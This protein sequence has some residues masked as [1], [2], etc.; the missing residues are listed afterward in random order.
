MSNDAAPFTSP[1]IRDPDGF[2]RGRH[3]I[4]TPL[5]A[6][7]DPQVLLRQ[8][9][10]ELRAQ[11]VTV[12]LIAL[13]DGGAFASLMERARR[14]DDPSC[15]LRGRA[16][17][18]DGVYLPPPAEF[19][20]PSSGDVWA[21]L[22]LEAEEAVRTCH[23]VYKIL[24]TDTVSRVDSWDQVWGTPV[25]SSSG[26]TSLSYKP[27]R[28]D[29]PGER[30]SPLFRRLILDHAQEQTRFA[31]DVYRA[32]AEAQDAHV[33]SQFGDPQPDRAP[34]RPGDRVI[35]QMDDLQEQLLERGTPPPLTERELEARELY[36]SAP[37][38]EVDSL[39]PLDSPTP[40]T[41]P[42]REETPDHD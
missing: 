6:D 9:V 5:S 13:K 16:C 18:L 7:Q 30:N 38:P 8:A 20:P 33:A 14:G 19:S 12:S 25:T 3:T 11:G 10:Q 39:L 41:T 36:T 21:F 17:V 40:P 4:P 42:P 37:D 24:G 35:R 31:E 34:L 2:L 32:V 1:L 28:M 15:V 22:M 27:P 29:G 26:L 23:G